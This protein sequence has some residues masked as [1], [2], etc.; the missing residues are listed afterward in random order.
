[1]GLKLEVEPV[2][3]RGN[4]VTIKLGLEV[5]NALNPQKTELGSTY[6]TIGTRN[7]TTV[8]RLHDGENQ[9]LAGLI[10]N[11]DRKTANK[12]P[13]LGQLPGFKRIFGSS[14]DSDKRSEI[15]LSITPRIVR[16]SQRP[17]GRFSE[18]RSGTESRAMGAGSG[19]GGWLAAPALP[20]EPMTPAA[21]SAAEAPVADAP[22]ASDKP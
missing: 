18:F 7:A 11:E 9:V 10:N 12:V 4:D 1:V 13:G 6:Y 8:L 16:N 15:V 19:T 2:I 17:E 22:P 20:A 14:E 5:S 3:Y 21:K